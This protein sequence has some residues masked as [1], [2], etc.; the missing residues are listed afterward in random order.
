MHWHTNATTR[1]QDSQYAT[2]LRLACT[3]R[4]VG[5]L[6]L[7]AHM[8]KAPARCSTQVRSSKSGSTYARGGCKDRVDGTLS[9]SASSRAPKPSRSASLAT[10]EHTA[11]VPCRRCF[12]TVAA[13]APQLPGG[14]NIV[15]A[16]IAQI[17]L[18]TVEIP[19][20]M[21]G[22]HASSSPP[23]N[24]GQSIPCVAAIRSSTAQNASPLRKIAR[25]T[26]KAYVAPTADAN[27]PS[28]NTDSMC[29]KMP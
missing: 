27:L 6:N 15:T 17:F 18:R 10:A 2:A 26:T 8:H 5:R 7:S 4:A 29:S 1:C 21:S 19:A 11:S 16:A 22:S 12:A 14:S 3:K 20:W 9:T 13:S 28:I 24:A 25:P 23:S